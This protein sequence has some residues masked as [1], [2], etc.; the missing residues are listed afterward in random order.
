MD[1]I[2]RGM[3]KSMLLIGGMLLV[4][5]VYKSEASRGPILPCF[6][7][8]LTGLYCPGCG[9]TRA[10]NSLMHLDICQSIRYNAMPLLIGPLLILERLLYSKKIDTRV[11]S[12]VMAIIVLV[13]GVLRNTA[14]FS[15]LAPTVI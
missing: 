5:Y 7:Y 12:V 8:E 15:F 1:K 6:I 4:L 2:K 9:M 10:V 13:Y 11:L 14:I 3:A